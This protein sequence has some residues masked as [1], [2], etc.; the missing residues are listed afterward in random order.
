M[1]IVFIGTVDFSYTCLKAM[2]DI[3]ADVTGIFTQTKDQARLNSDW[4][5]LTPLG[6]K[7]RVPVNFFTKIGDPE[8]LKKIQELSPDI[9]F[10]LGLSQLLPQPLLQ[11]SPQGVIGSHP[12]LLPEN[13]GRHPLIWAL[14]K[15]LPKSGLTLFYI[16]A[17][18]DSGDIVMQR[19]FLITVTDTAM[20]LY[21][22]I[23]ELG[24]EMVRELIPLLED[25]KAPR[26][27]QDHRKATYLRKRNKEDGLLHWEEGAWKSYNLIRALTYPY[28]GAHT[29]F[30][31]QEIKVWSA[32]PPVPRAGGRENGHFPGEII[33]A[34]DQ[35][36]TVWAKDGPL[37]INQLGTD[38]SG[39]KVGEVFQHG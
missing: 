2:L 7:Y 33:E 19:E 6:K 37:T 13:R 32:F 20:D 9:I 34:A 14:V 1:R 10:V 29:F 11:I 22:K 39:L 23:E 3:G 17:G 25:G 38:P 35:G 21:A 24:A 36:I 26:I 16:D 31:G 12:A 5:D 4:A 15:G 27:P 18:V 28:V 30:N 8:V